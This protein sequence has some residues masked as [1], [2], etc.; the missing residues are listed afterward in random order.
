LSLNCAYFRQGNTLF[1]KALKDAFNDLVNREVGNFKTGKIMLLIII[2]I[3]VVDNDD[4]D[5][6]DDS[7]DDGCDDEDDDDDDDD[8]VYNDQYDDQVVNDGDDHHFNL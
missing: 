3:Y 2:N 7:N 4:S 1:Q 5:V 8:D 6:S